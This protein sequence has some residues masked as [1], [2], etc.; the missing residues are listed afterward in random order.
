L[1]SAGMLFL[2]GTSAVLFLAAMLALIFKGASVSV[3]V[4]FSVMT[5]QVFTIPFAK[6]APII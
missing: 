6:Y 3:H 4:R 5:G 2:I 1:T